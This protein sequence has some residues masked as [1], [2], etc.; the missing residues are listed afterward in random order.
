MNSLSIKEQEGTLNGHSGRVLLIG[1][2][3][4]TRLQFHSGRLLLEKT[5]LA[6][7]FINQV[8]GDTLTGSSQVIRS[9]V[10]TS[11]DQDQPVL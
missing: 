8:L 5:R 9:L 7:N 2:F 1:M 6:G 3:K 4:G 10:Q 11:L